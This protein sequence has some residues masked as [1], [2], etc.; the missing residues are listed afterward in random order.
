MVVAFGGRRFIRT[1]ERWNA[2]VYGRSWA[3][4]EASAPSEC[5]WMVPGTYEIL[6]QPLREE[7]AR[8][9]SNRAN[10]SAK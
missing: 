7:V 3:M 4:G 6:D 2:V 9:V 5:E 1:G 8:V 10:R